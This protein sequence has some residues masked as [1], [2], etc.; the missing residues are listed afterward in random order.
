MTEVEANRIN[1]MRAAR[2][3]PAVVLQEYNNLR[4]KTPGKIIFAFEGFEDVVFYGVMAEKSELKTPYGV[5]VCRGKDRVLDLMDLLARNKSG[6]SDLVKYFVDHDFDGLK[7]RAANDDTYCTQT[8]SIENHLVSPSILRQILVG[9]FRCVGSN[10]SEEVDRAM[11]YFHRVMDSYT[12]AFFQ[13]NLAIFSLRKNRVDSGTIENDLKKY[14]T[15]STDGVRCELELKDIWSLTG[16]SKTLDLAG[17]ETMMNEAEPG[18]GGL[19]PLRNWRG[20]YLL[21][22]FQKVLVLLKEDRGRKSDWQIFQS[23]AAV[24]ANFDGNIV[25]ALSSLA[26]LPADLRS[27]FERVDKHAAA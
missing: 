5:L 19:D 8:Y 23:R 16:A 21:S 27:F 10:G 6:D 12:V 17:L 14:V 2:Q 13:V 24:S 18:F 9:E 3:A 20:K 7:D 1:E 25:R 22:I 11:D 15:I 4:S 26:P